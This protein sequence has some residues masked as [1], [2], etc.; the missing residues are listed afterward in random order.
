MEAEDGEEILISVTEVLGMIQCTL[1]L[2]GNASEYILQTRRTNILESIDPSW[3]SYAA[4]E[5][6]ELRTPSSV[7]PFR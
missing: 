3:S 7:R 4:E 6:L 2:V 1:G 5:F